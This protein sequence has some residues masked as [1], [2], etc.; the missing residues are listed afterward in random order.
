MSERRDVLTV[1]EA[2]G[3]RPRQP[4]DDPPLVPARAPDAV[5]G[6]AGCRHPHPRGRAAGAPA[7]ASRTSRDEAPARA[8]GRRAPGAGHLD[9][10]RAH[11]SRGPPAC[12]LRPRH[13]GA[14]GRPAG[15]R[16]EGKCRAWT[17][18]DGGSGRTGKAPCTAG[19]VWVRTA[20]RTSAGSPRSAS[21]GAT[22]GGSCAASAR[23]SRRRRRPWRSCSVPPS[24]C[25]RSASSRL[26]PT[27][28]GGS[29]RPRPPRCSPSTLRGYRDALAHLA[30]IADIPLGAAA[31]RGHRAGSGGHDDAPGACQEAGAG[32]TEDRA[33]CPGLPAPRPRP[34]R[35]ARPH[36][37]ERGED[38]AAALG[39][40]APRRGP[41]A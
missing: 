20:S 21:A 18:G 25:R 9:G 32:L 2:A 39:A 26:A 11:R 13:P 29:M 35:A 4:G 14:R 37:P 40:P 8:G 16:G 31:T 30:P 36:H 27:S 23:R 17:R 15:V 38:G 28:D 5:P 1:K 34:G 19:R 6:R 41:H 33:Q 22:T 12:P 7:A 10:V 24:P 3:G